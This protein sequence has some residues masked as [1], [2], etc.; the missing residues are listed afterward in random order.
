M[1]KGITLILNLASNLCNMQCLYCYEHN[2]SKYN[3]INSFTYAKLNEVKEYLSQFKEYPYIHILFH[4]GEPLLFGKDNLEKI[5]YF[6]KNNFKNKYRLQVQTNGTLI[7]NDFTEIFIKYGVELSISLDPYGITDLRKSKNFEYRNIVINN[8]LMSSNRLNNI[9]IVSVAHRYN[10]NYFKEFIDELIKYN[11]KYLTINKI[12]YSEYYRKFYIMEKEYND[13]LKE[14][15]LYWIKNKKYKLIDIQPFISLLTDHKICIYSSDKNKCNYFRTFYNKEYNTNYC[16]HIIND[17]P[18]IDNK[19]QK[20]Y[21]Y[22]WCGSGCL[23][24]YKDNTFCNSRK[25]FK[26]FLGTIHL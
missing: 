18:T 7:D 13:M 20:C 16:S 19:C 8:I 17:I 22:E 23:V 1:N 2:I 21:I 9:G 5:F 10:L 4:G 3:K 24:E 11:I 6:I 25:D 15:L 14:L 26:K 12:R